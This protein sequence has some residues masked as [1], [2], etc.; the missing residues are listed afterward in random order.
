MSSPS[1]D[2]IGRVEYEGG[3]WGTVTEVRLRNGMFEYVSRVNM[4]HPSFDA[5]RLRLYGDDGEMI[6]QTGEDSPPSWQPARDTGGST[7]VTH[8]FGVAAPGEMG[9]AVGPR[10]C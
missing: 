8:S 4:P 7:W 2:W 3:V 1:T 5:S 9:Q 10:R 6:M